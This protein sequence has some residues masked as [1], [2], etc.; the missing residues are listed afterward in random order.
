MGIILFSKCKTGE[1]N[2]LSAFQMKTS[3]KIL[4]FFLWKREVWRF[5]TVHHSAFWQHD[6]T[7]QITV[8]FEKSV[9]PSQLL[10]VHVMGHAPPRFFLIE[11]P[12]RGREL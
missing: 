6:Q 11:L 10:P 9:P 12:F 7:E 2:D 1:K 3:L 5:W 4:T 8:P